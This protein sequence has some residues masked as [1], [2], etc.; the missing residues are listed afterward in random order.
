MIVRIGELQLEAQVTAWS[1]TQATV[2]L[3]Q[4]PMAGSVKATVVVVTAFGN[5]AD[6][7][8]VE[9]IPGS[10][11][12]G[13]HGGPGPVATAEKP[14]VSPGQQVT[15]E[16]RDMGSQPGRVQL[17]VGGLTL[18]ATVSRWSATEAVAVLPTLNFANPVDATIQIVR[19]DGRTVDQVDVVFA[20]EAE[21]AAR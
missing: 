8:D 15:L 14:V 7:L 10:N 20:P 1:G 16:G 17:Q 6:T 12:G 13:D 9:I 21:V 3:P 11:R 19:A 5:I 4:L 18:N 2:V